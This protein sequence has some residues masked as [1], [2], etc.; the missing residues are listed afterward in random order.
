MESV[1]QETELGTE[2]AEAALGN[3]QLTSPNDVWERVFS[4]IEEADDEDA[5]EEELNK[6]EDNSNNGIVDDAEGDTCDDLATPVSA[7]LAVR[8][9]NR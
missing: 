2:V 6:E 9:S 5:V 7:A 1:S 3:D 4:I 8:K